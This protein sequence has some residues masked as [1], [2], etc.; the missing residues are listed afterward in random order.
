MTDNG[1]SESYDNL[2]A[3]GM[4][5]LAPGERWCIID[6]GGHPMLSTAS[7]RM[8]CP[9]VVFCEALECDWEDAKDVGYSLGR[10]QS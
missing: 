8:D 7:E 4:R 10:T 5:G 2:I 6:P 3:A 9:V 1:I